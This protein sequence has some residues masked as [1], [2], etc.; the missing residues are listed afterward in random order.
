[1]LPNI[2]ILTS[3]ETGSSV[4]A[5]LLA[6]AGF[7]LGDET[8]EVAYKTFENSKLIDLN[9]KILDATD[10]GWYDSLN[11]PAPVISQIKDALNC[12]DCSEHKQFAESCVSNSPFLWKDPRLSYT[13]YFW[14]QIMD[15]SSTKFIVM[16]RDL[17]Q[18]WTGTVL[19]GKF[20]IA[21][22]DMKTVHDNC[23]K[24]ATD[25][26]KSSGYEYLHITFEEMISSPNESLDKLNSFLSVKLTLDDLKGVYRGQLGC[27]RWSRLDFFKAKLK[28]LYYKFFTRDV[29]S[30]PRKKIV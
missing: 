1:M 29:V 27:I 2:I 17:N 26:L 7:W 3:G 28:L 30:F 9:K 14:D 18:S 8:A 24:Y 16:T 15:L 11:L 10:Y 12:M 21:L 25:Y 20:P 23:F 13:I 6:K 19:R 22:D 4:L 5:G